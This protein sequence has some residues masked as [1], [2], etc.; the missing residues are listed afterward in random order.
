MPYNSLIIIKL[1][2]F[3][4]FYNRRDFSKFNLKYSAP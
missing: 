4:L 1:L 2:G 3:E